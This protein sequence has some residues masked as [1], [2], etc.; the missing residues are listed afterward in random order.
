MLMI[1]KEQLQKLTNAKTQLE[2]EREVFLRKWKDIA[3]QMSLSYGGWGH[4]ATQK[5]LDDTKSVY[6]N[7]ANESSNLMADGLMGSCFG[8]SIAWFKMMF[9]DEEKNIN[10]AAAG[11]LSDT[12]KRIYKQLNRSNFYDES[13][14]FV[15]GDAD[16][17]TAVMWMGDDTTEGMP[18]FKFLHLKDVCLMEDRFGR[19]DTLFRDFWLTKD[20]AIEFFGEDR[21]PVTI[22]QSED[23]TKKWKFC[24][25]VGP[26]GRFRLNVK[27]E[28]EYISVY[29]CGEKC[30]ESIKE[31]RYDAK[32]FVA[33]RWNRDPEG[34]AYGTQ[35]PG[36]MQL[37]NIKTVNILSENLLRKS[38]LI[39][40]PPI[41]RTEGLIINIKPAGVTDLKAGEDFAP[42]NVTGDLSFTEVERERLRNCIKEA[43]YTNFFLMLARSVDKT[44]T[45][46]EVAALMN[47]QSNIMAAFFNRLAAE[48]L[49]PVLRFVYDLEYKNGRLADLPEEIK[50]EFAGKP[51]KIVFVSPMFLMQKQ[52]HATEQPMKALAQIMTMA[53]ANPDILMKID[54][55]KTV[56][57]IAEGYSVK[58][59][60]LLD[61]EK[62]RLLKESVAQQRAQEQAMAQRMAEAKMGAENYKNLSGAPEQGSAAEAMINGR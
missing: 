21:L 20:E 51:L 31:E 30:D 1:T 24:Q 38:Q 43:Y 60:I 34:S 62:Y 7:T 58:K 18:F 12:E 39:A 52:S 25:Y 11:W 41:K 9:E 56:D 15:R 6:D 22:K 8:R 59:E 26:A 23:Y 50:G 54:W 27:G 57:N 2:T 53:Q 42:V 37:S 16:F 4:E 47:E 3:R 46:T 33:L 49:E 5:S 35:G 14:T 19:V 36:L 45:A 32:P 48:F 61:E 29:W 13:R 10:E 55:D 40:S 28:G 17:S 44:K